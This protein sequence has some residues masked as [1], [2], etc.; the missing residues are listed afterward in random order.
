MN[1][2]NTLLTS[3]EYDLLVKVAKKSKMDCWFSLQQD[4]N[5]YDYVLD[6]ESGKKLT[7]KEGVKD[8]VDGLCVT[9]LDC[10][11]NEEML[12]FLQLLG[13]LI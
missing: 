6:V 9:N 5:G 11:N 3:S 13:A 2:N 7:L 8:L 4:K 10:L 1:G 12:T